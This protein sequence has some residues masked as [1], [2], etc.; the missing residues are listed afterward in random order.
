VPLYLA[1]M[2]NS[3]AIKKSAVKAKVPEKF[4]T[5]G[6]V[7]C[8]G[9]GEEF[10]IAHHAGRTSLI[11]AE[12]Q[13]T[14]WNG[15]SRMNTSARRSMRIAS[16]CRSEA[17]SSTAPIGLA[18]SREAEARTSSTYLRLRAHKSLVAKLE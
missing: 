11:V 4:E 9:C 2:G 14:G 5:I 13:A 3:V 16:S 6:T 15:C 18:V 7:R 12:H 10:L 8:E 1:S 17:Q